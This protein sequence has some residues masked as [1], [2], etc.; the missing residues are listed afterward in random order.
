[1][2]KTFAALALSAAIAVP[3]LGMVGSASAS[4]VAAPRHTQFSGQSFTQTFN[5]SGIGP[6]NYSSYLVATA[7]S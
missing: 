3:V 7:H 6:V 4:T 2:R 1:M 5:F